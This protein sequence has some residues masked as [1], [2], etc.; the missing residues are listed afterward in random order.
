MHSRASCVLPWKPDGTKGRQSKFP[1]V[2]CQKVILLTL[3]YSRFALRRGDVNAMT[4]V[5]LVLTEA[6]HKLQNLTGMVTDT[7]K[8]AKGVAGAR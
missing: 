1:K 3:G 7:S 4:Q 8:D 2:N 5:Q 6:Y